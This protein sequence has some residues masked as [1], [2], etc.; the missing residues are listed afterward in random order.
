V[1]I[2]GGI[3]AI[4]AALIL[5]EHQ[6]DFILLEAS[7]RIGGRICTVTIGQAVDEN[8]FNCDFPWLQ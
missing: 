2:G 7:N 8:C 5:A 3:S 1:I 6:Q 4:Q